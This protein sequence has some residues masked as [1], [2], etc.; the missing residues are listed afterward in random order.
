[1]K[2]LAKSLKLQVTSLFFITI[3]TV[4]ALA[5][6]VPSEMMLGDLRLTIN[7]STR[8]QIQKDVDR[9]T[10]SQTYFNILVDRMNLYFPIIE[11]EHGG[12]GIPD[13]IKFLAIQESALISDAVSS[14]NAVGFWQ[15]KDFTAREVGLTV[16]RNVDERLNIVSASRG[17]A[18]YLNSH[19][20][21]LKNWVYSVM[22]YNTGR[23]G[24]QKYVDDS[25]LGAKRM[26]IN[27][28]THWYVKKF[29]AHVVA[30]SPAVGR[31]HSEGIWLDE[32]TNAG[33][34]SLEQIARE[35]KVDLEELKKYN[36]W[37]K[38]GSVPKDKTYA[39]LIPRTGTP[40]KRAI[41]ENSRRNKISTPQTK[42]YPTELKPG[43]TEKN[44]STIIPLNGIPSILS[45]EN[46]DVHTISAR[47][48]I[49]E[50]KFRKYNDMADA[51]KVIPNEFYYVKKKKG[52]AK[53][54]FHVAQKGE[55][56]WEISQQYGIKI[57][58]LA[59]RNRMSITDDLKPGRVLWMDKTRPSDEPIAYHELSAP[60]ITKP[61]AKPV[62]STNGVND[63][64]ISKESVEEPIDEE[65]IEEEVPDIIVPVVDTKEERLS[66]VKIHT[67]AAGETLWSISRLY[68]VT[69]DDLLRWNE[70]P[71]PDAVSIG[72]NIQVK[73]PIEEASVGKNI[74]NHTVQPG[75]TVYAISRKYGMT[76]DEVVDL[77]NLKGFDLSVGQDLRVYN[78]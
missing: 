71:N 7:E 5:Q 47:A 17:S 16:D 48:G 66:K 19:N 14:A 37:L 64:L 28:Q 69:M 46:D 34:K 49:S 67:I 43:I 35:E 23:G 73:A 9:L 22:A 44:K 27:N 55:S 13:Q 53:I 42:I 30:F 70:L 59:S 74:I 12:A 4:G 51:D 78:Q 68:E 32:V 2:Q 76:V 29:I 45:R 25:N 40:P 26:T 65:I 38:R 57:S 1:M 50:K 62:A 6:T 33:G 21:F 72:Q 77:N 10:Q 36:K 20:F 3:S 24:A 11:R 58:K 52:K 54:G 75:E 56:L 60:V 8:K 61:V 39:V 63:A 41:A 15:F 18:K 31:P